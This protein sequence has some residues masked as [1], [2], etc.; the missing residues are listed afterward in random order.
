MSVPHMISGDGN[1]ALILNGKQFYVQKDD[2]VR[3]QV[4]TLLKEEASAD[5]ILSLID[6][7]TPVI[8]YLAPS[9]RMESLP[10]K[11]KKFTTV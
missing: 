8:N 3:E 6:K 4:L 1:I 2:T 10:I 11:E 9:L 7:T 5:D